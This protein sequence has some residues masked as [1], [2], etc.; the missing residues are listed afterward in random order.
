MAETEILELEL[1]DKYIIY[2]FRALY[3]ATRKGNGELLN[4]EQLLR[5]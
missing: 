4:S 1:E 5:V 3:L 2:A